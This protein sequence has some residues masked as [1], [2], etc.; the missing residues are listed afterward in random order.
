MENALSKNFFGYWIKGNSCIRVAMFFISLFFVCVLN[1]QDKEKLISLHLKNANLKEL[2]D[3]IEDVTD[4]YV[5]YRD[6]LVDDKNN[7]SVNIENEALSEVLKKILLPKKLQANFVKNTIIITVLEDKSVNKGEPIEKSKQT[8]DI[9]GIVK[10]VNGE[11]IVGST[12]TIL[13]TNIG[14]V[15]DINGKFLLK[16]VPINSKIR[17][18]YVGYATQ[19][20]SV[21]K[22]TNSFNIL[23]TEDSEIL[24]EVVVVGYGTQRKADITGSIASVNV[25]DFKKVI[26]NN[27]AQALQGMAAGVNVKNYGLPGDNSVI[28]IRGVS[29]FGNNTPLVIV[30]GI[31]Q[32]MNYL[33]SQD[34]ESIQVLKDARV[35]AIYGVRGSNGV[36]LVTTKKGAKGTPKVSYSGNVTVTFPLGNNPFNLL[37][38]DE[39]MQVVNIGQPGNELFQNGMPDYLFTSPLLSGVAFEGDSEVDPSK[40]YYENPNK[41]SNYLIQR[42]NKIGT[43]WFCEAFKTALTQDHNLSVSGGNDYSRYYFS[44]GYLDQKGTLTET[45]LKRLSTRINTEFKIGKYIKVGENI[46]LFY[47]S[48]LP[49]TTGQEYGGIAALYK[50]P[51]I[52]P[53]KDIMGNWGGTAIGPELGVEDNMIANLKRNSEFSDYDSYNIVGNIYAQIDFLKDFSFRT[54]VGLNNYNNRIQTF[55]SARAENAERFSEPNILNLEFSQ[56]RTITFSNTLSYN[57]TIALKHRINA[58]IGTETVKS[59]YYTMTSQSKDYDY[60]FDNYLLLQLGNERTP[61]SSSKS[62]TALLSFFGRVDYNYND[63]Y[64]FGVTLRRDGS[65]LFGVNNRWGTF[66]SFSAAWRIS[67]E[68]FMKNVSWL[69]DLKLRISYGILGSQNN[70]SATNQYTTYKADINTTAYDINGTSNSVVV[71]MAQNRIGNSS[72]GWEKDIIKNIGIDAVLFNNSFDFQIDLY[73]KSISGLL[74]TEPLPAVIGASVSQPTINIGDIQNVGIDFTARYRFNISEFRN[75]VSLNLDTYKNKIVKLPDPGYFGENYRNQVGYPTGMFYGYKIVG[76]FKNQDQIDVAAEQ[77]GAAIGRFQYENINGDDKITP[78]DRQFLASPH[79][80]F[81][82]GLV[83]SSEFKG[84]D[85]SAQFYGVYGNT[86]F[87]QT[88][89][90]TDFFQTGV[91]NNK[92]KRILDA[93]TPENTDTTVPKIDNASSFSSDGAFNDYALEDGS[94]LRLKALTIGYNLN[95]NWKFMKQLHIS[96]FRISATLNNVFTITKYSGLDPE[97]AAGSPSAFGIDT[98]TYP[99][100]ERRFTFGINLTF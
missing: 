52:I 44:I 92:S 11:P 96:Q 12:V 70:V 78:E 51:P 64:L 42:V 27:A 83:L 93:W 97:I 8:K 91:T 10:D 40:Y 90:S 4:F 21:N 45:F 98:A 24:N 77:D 53:V 99:T 61:G 49:F 57:K 80:D 35:A 15:T 79:P 16:N 55:T 66:P 38:S 84:F 20:I 13:D 88:R 69:N 26:A 68:K 36:I 81:S 9:I 3:K 39:Y 23:L 41:G 85:I 87:N 22:K 62:R 30:D 6:V 86:I 18:T 56:G 100:N 59:L 72:T 71:G 19:T 33:N 2:F 43:D 54:S 60:I 65:S 28:S 48:K 25:N 31:E 76:I 46:N 29:S 7:I 95:N 37:N 67:Q 50:L 14:T 1:A 74:L 34:I 73:K 17:I 82:M 32:S 47:N 94:Y 58:L 75:Q 63:K 89:M 5:V